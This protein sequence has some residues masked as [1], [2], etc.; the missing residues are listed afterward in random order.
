MTGKGPR[1][2]HPMLDV[3]VPFF[4]PLWR[5]IV[6]VLVIAVWVAVEL[7]RGS[8]WWALLAGGIGLY[9]VHQFFFAFDPDGGDQE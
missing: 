5:R 8:L 4:V 7:A 2:R 6:T 9:L 1:R 3:Q